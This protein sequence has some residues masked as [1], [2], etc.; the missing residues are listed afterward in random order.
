MSQYGAI[1]AAARAV[2]RRM[3]RSLRGGRITIVDGAAREQFGAPGDLDATLHVL[4]PSLWRRALGGGGVGFAEAYVDGLW[5][6]DDIVP[7]LRVL[8]RNIDRLNRVLRN[9]LTRVRTLTAP[10]D[11]FR[12]PDE[13]TDRRNIHAHYDL[14]D[15]FFKLF[16]DPTMAY[17]CAVFERPDMS[18]EEASVAKFDNLCTAL[19]LTRDSH[20]LEIGTGWGGLAVHAARRYGCRVTTTTISERQFAYAQDLVRRE[21]LQG[22]V[23]VLRE[24]YRDLRGTYSHLV[25]VEMIEAVDWRLYDEFFATIQRLLRPDGVAALQAIVVDDREFERSKRWKDFIKRYIFPGGCLPSVA[26]MLHT[27]RRA[28]DL[29]LV[30]LRDIGP[31]YAL[32]LRH[33]RNALDA[34]AEQVRALGHDERFLRTWRY[35]FAYCEA[36][37]AERR[38]S[39]VQVLFARPG[40]RAQPWAVRDAQSAAAVPDLHAFTGL[41]KTTLS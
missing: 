8:A 27:T 5:D 10:L 1:D 9:P 16:L 39:D 33:W 23:E 32:T 18:L 3:L 12:A 26:E 20:L 6:S 13:A 19:G 37:F 15:E 25:S 34:H 22:R 40:W 36:G 24:H 2:A 30:H 14:G 35:Y 11:R 29:S 17:S 21:E 38:I 41:Y 7:V 4:H 28:T 31:H